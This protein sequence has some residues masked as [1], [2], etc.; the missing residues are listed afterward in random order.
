M[1]DPL[2]DLLAEHADLE[3]RLADPAVHAD[4]A[5]A[6]E[7]GRRYAEIGPVVAAAPRARR[8]A[9]RP[10][11]RPRARDGRRDRRDRRQRIA[12]LDARIRE[13]LIPKDPADAK[14]VILEV[15]GGEGGDEA[16][17]FAGDLVRMY[18]RYAERA[19]L[20][21]RAGQR[22]RGRARRLQGHLARREEPRPGQPGVRPAEVRGR[23]APRA[24]GA[25]DREPGPHPH[26]RGGRARAA[27]GRGGRRADRPERPAHRRLPLQRPGRPERQHHR[28]G[29]AH[30][31]PADRRHREHAERE[32][33]AAEPRGGHARAALPAAGA[34][35]GGAGRQGQRRA[36]LADPHHGPQREGPDLQLP[37]QPGR[38]PPQRLQGQQPR[39]G[40]RRRPRRR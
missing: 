13:L 16:A 33:P 29:R 6:R 25:G 22:H 4:Q 20:E 31:A 23:R 14:D 17:L 36:R 26:Q 39:P 24:A 27:R 5:V 10:A 40:A 7:L 34:R 15:K 12:A 11:G 18:M 9:R 30:H 3:Q 38:R 2:D 28:L 32:E 35:A 21:D 8:A 19:G 1:A 37:G